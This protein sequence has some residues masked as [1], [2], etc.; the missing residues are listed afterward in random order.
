M[1]RKEERNLLH[2]LKKKGREEGKKKGMKEG[3]K[4]EGGR[5]YS[6]NASRRQ[7]LII[8]K[9]LARLCSIMIHEH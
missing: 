9:V 6:K 7:R 5:N 2:T 3:R 1:E 8:T 4:R